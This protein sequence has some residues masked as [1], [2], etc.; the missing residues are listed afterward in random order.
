MRCSR[1]ADLEPWLVYP[2][3]EIPEWAAAL[4]GP[5][6]ARNIL[7]FAQRQDMDDIACFDLDEGGISVIHPGADP[8][9]EQ[10]ARFDDVEGWFR[11]AISDY[12]AHDR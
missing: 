1:R 6:P 10:C 4:K 5:Y 8:G 3:G 9:S 11:A 7:P 2:P 12:I